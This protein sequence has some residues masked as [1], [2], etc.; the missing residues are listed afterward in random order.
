MAALDVTELLSW[1][2]GITGLLACKPEDHEHLA[3]D[4]L[5]FFDHTTNTE[6]PTSSSSS[7]SWTMSNSIP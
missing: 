6:A 1:E 2:N 4:V 3:E 5:R 7:P